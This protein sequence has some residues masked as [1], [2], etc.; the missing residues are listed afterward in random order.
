MLLPPS[1][2]KSR[3]AV[4]FGS[5]QNTDRKLTFFFFFLF[6]ERSIHLVRL[7]HWGPQ[8]K[9]QNS[10]GCNTGS[11]VFSFGQFIIMWQPLLLMWSPAPHEILNSTVRNICHEL[12]LHEWGQYDCPLRKCSTHSLSE[13]GELNMHWIVSLPLKWTAKWVCTQ[14]QVPIYSPINYL[15]SV[16]KHC[17]WR[18]S[19]F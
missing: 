9:I 6:S 19:V 4:F 8:S 15:D 16:L 1:E 2:T 5:I 18:P 7:I 3:S 12:C 13:W 17:S 10:F 14:Y 11:S